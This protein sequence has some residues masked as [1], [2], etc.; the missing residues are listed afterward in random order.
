MITF[1][2]IEWDYNNLQGIGYDSTTLLEPYATW[3]YQITGALNY[4]KE[5]INLALTDDSE[6]NP[7]YKVKEPT[8]TL[9]DYSKRYAK[10]ISSESFNISDNYNRNVYRYNSE[11]ISLTDAKVSD[12]KRSNKDEVIYLLDEAKSIYQRTGENPVEIDQVELS[13]SACLFDFEAN[14][15]V[16]NNTDFIDWCNNNSPVNYNELRPFIPGEYEYTDAYVGF[17]LTIPSTSGRFGV[18]HSTVYVDVED[19]VGK[20]VVEHSYNTQT[21]QWEISGGTIDNGVVTVD[22]SKRFYTW[23]Q[24]M[25]SLNFSQ[26]N[27]FIEVSEVNQEYF[28]FKIKSVSTG[29]YVTDTVAWSI[30]WLADGY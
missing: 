3:F 20:G 24:I 28:K 7:T 2:G 29:S 14:D 9:R 10:R 15:G 30:N 18:A 19:T 6:Y 5:T 13:G 23:P 11:N 22:F 27:C 8:L 1:S 17:R 26:E 21:S 4:E 12:L 25:T 16:W